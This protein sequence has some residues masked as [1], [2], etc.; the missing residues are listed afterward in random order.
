M[1]AAHPITVDRPAGNEADRLLIETWAAAQGSPLTRKSYRH[2]GGR[3][4]DR[5]GKPLAAV[6]V[7][8][9]QAFVAGLGDL[10]PATIG[11]AV[12]AVKSLYAFGI[13]TGALASNPAGQLQAPSIKNV[14]AER[15]LEEEDVR[16]L[17]RME[18]SARNRALLLLFYGAGLRRHELCR[19]E[20]RDLA[21]RGTDRGQA[22]V[23]GKG[24]KT[25]TVM[26][27][28]G[29]WSALQ[30]LRGEAGPDAPVFRSQKG[31]ALDPSA[32]HRVVKAACARAGLPEGA[33][34]HWLRHSF[35]SHALDRGAS[36][37]LVQQ[38]LGHASVATTSKY[39]HAR[40]SDGAG[41]FLDLGA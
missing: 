16:R 26:L 39:L 29:V 35:A 30:D 13:E 27:F 2:Q 21:G 38:G 22:T 28:G 40:P 12:A 1:S 10:A 33:S 14:L 5:I 3:L 17:I 24:G 6:A 20:W 15:I 36:L 37:S 23:F 32:V 9:L 34:P 18:P 11:L 19:L 8:D 41:R 7:A 4:L 25:R 31:G